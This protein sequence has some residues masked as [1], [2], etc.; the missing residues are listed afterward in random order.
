MNSKASL[1]VMSHLSDIQET[2][3]YKYEF[4][5]MENKKNNNRIKFVKFIILECNGNLNQEIN[6]EEYWEKFTQTRFYKI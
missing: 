6:P 3:G 2:I 1:V 5:N 4:Q